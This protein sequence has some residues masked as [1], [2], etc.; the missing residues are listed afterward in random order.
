MALRILSAESIVT[1]RVALAELVFVS[2]HRWPDELY[3]KEYLY[4]YLRRESFD[5]ALQEEVEPCF[6]FTSFKIL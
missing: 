4:S 6:G 3:L 2:A 1:K 5:E